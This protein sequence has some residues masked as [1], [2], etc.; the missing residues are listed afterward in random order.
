MR[1]FKLLSVVVTI[2]FYLFLSAASQ[3]RFEPN[4]PCIEVS[5]VLNTCTV[6]CRFFLLKNFNGP[7]VLYFSYHILMILG[8]KVFIVWKLCFHVSVP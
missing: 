4:F 5:C 2:F 6:S 1:S 7:K 3:S 8:G